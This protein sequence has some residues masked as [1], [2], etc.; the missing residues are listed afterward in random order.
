M[1]EVGRFEPRN[2][3]RDLE[4]VL[5][6]RKNAADDCRGHDAVAYGKR[7]LD[8]QHPPVDQVRR[9]EIDRA[10]DSESERQQPDRDAHPKTGADQAAAFAH[11]QREI[12]RGESADQSADQQGRVDFAEENAAP[13]AHEY[14]GVKA[15]I[16]IEKDAEHERRERVRRHQADGFRPEKTERTAVAKDEEK[17]R[18]GELDENDSE[19]EK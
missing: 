14:R 11:L 5:E 10:D 19:H 4:E 16:A 1:I 15:V 3:R 8:A 9:K 7:A 17:L 13:K 12:D 2:I 18:R 6:H